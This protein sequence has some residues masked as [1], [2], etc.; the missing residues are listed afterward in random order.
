MKKA[1]L[2]KL[3]TETSSEVIEKNMDEINRRTRLVIDKV[4][5]EDGK[6]SAHD[7]ATALAGLNIALCPELSAVITAKMLVK[8]GLIVLEDDE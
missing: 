6:V 1:E 3:A 8:L 4:S 7:A 5:N 2:Y